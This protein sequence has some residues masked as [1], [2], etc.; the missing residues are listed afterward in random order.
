MLCRQGITS[1]WAFNPCRAH[2]AKPRSS[3]PPVQCPPRSL[4][5]QHQTAD[6]AAEAPL[7]VYSSSSTDTATREKS[8]SW[9]SKQKPKQILRI[10]RKKK[11][12]WTS[13]SLIPAKQNRS[14]T[15]A[16]FLSAKQS[17]ANQNSYYS[18]C[19]RYTRN[20]DTFLCNSDHSKGTAYL[21]SL[22]INGGCRC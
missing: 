13:E 6:A 9:L 4:N 7:C 12:F 19:T 14:R 5:H 3:L 16:R 20:T 1:P 11:W 18:L 2:C 8:G 15:C 21:H 22:F 17:L 10:P